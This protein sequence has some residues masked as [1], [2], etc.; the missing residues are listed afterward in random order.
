M[1][2]NCVS[3]FVVASAALSAAGQTSGIPFEIIA[4]SDGPAPGS[5]GLFLESFGFTEA[6]V[7]PDRA[8]A[9]AST[10]SALDFSNR[11][12][13]PFYKPAG[14]PIT[15]I[16][17]SEAIDF[18]SSNILT[19]RIDDK[20]RAHVYVTVFNPMFE[21]I[22][23]AT[24]PDGAGNATP[25]FRTTDPIPGTGLVDQNY[26]YPFRPDALGRY[27]I[28]GQ[29]FLNEPPFSLNA[30]WLATPDGPT[31]VRQSGDEVVPGS[32]V[33]ALNPEAVATSLDGTAFGIISRGFDTP[34]DPGDPNTQG[35]G[36]IF[37]NVPLEDSPNFDV[38]DIL[39]GPGGQSFLP[40]FINF[41]G[42][43]SGS[44]AFWISPRNAVVSAQGRLIGD[45]DQQ[46]RTLIILLDPQFGPR[47]IAAT[48][49]NIPGTIRKLDVVNDVVLSED[50]DRLHIQYFSQD[51]GDLVLLY[52]DLDGAE[53]PTFEALTRDD[54]V[55]L[56]PNAFTGG[57]TDDGRAF[58]FFNELDPEGG[59]LNT[60][61]CEDGYGTLRR[62]V[63]SGDR[64]ALPNFYSEF[65]Q[66]VGGIE[67][68][69]INDG[70]GSNRCGSILVMVGG[71]FP[72]GSRQG[73]TALLRYDLPH[74]DRNCDGDLDVA[75]IAIFI[76]DLEAMNPTSDANADG[77][78]N[79]FDLLLHLQVIDAAE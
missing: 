6:T 12:V 52:A 22:L 11:Q 3:A 34:G 19:P 33:F 10:I 4:R 28:S 1:N 35:F 77:E 17:L 67:I 68:P 70:G 61:L 76:D 78:L 71:G 74:P 49:T 55:K 57:M 16:T 7:G 53:Y 60:V 25:V 62:V 66:S 23:F 37:D 42:L 59:I 29:A 47:V 13:R 73:A 63:A 38:G 14:G 5:P 54:F 64:P 65:T 75:D 36:A 15:P 50:G 56:E 8:V 26:R 46:S 51:L 41:A 40:D 21:D 24:G 45:P 9:F 32:G 79:V 39:P 2:R 43:S 27:S 44:T 30:A 69:R 20:G 31:D 48:D 58:I 72:A 18:A